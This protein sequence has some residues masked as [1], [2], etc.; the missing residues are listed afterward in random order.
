M[1]T[2]FITEITSQGR[3]GKENENH[4]VIWRFWYEIMA[5]IQ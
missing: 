3:K 2:A 4:P 5:F 1:K